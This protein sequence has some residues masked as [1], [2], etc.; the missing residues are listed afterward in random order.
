MTNGS[1][2][3]KAWEDQRSETTHVGK[4][5][6]KIK[7]GRPHKPEHGRDMSSER[8][9]RTCVFVCAG[10][11]GEAEREAHPSLEIRPRAAA[12]THHTTHARDGSGI[13][14]PSRMESL[15]VRPNEPKNT[16]NVT[17]YTYSYPG[18][19]TYCRNALWNHVNHHTRG[20]KNCEAPQGVS[21]QLS[22]IKVSLGSR[23]HVS[24]Q[25]KCVPTHQPPEEI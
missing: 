24:S 3:D 15:T 2:K 6:R 12:P 19:G 5:P 25:E 14:R 21:A 23:C 8:E 16:Y 17:P 4:K 20:L 18:S 7:R 13:P 10:V 22:V 11:W 9:T 1:G